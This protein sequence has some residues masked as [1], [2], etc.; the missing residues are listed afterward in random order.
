MIYR[1]PITS[2]ISDDTDDTSVL[3]WVTDRVGEN[4]AIFLPEFC[5]MRSSGE[6]ENLKK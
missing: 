3:A 6:V 4:S 2:I 5:R 1:N